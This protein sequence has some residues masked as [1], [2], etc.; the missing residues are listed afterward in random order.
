[1]EEVQVALPPELWNYILLKLWEGE[2]S[3]QSLEL[4]KAC[5][6]A[7]LAASAVCKAWYALLDRNWKSLFISHFSEQDLK[8]TTFY[9][10]L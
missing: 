4:A 10:F 7:L 8:V 3:L 5:V 1:M 2:A 6:S 9:S